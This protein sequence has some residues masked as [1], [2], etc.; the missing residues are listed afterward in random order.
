MNR[1]ST[2]VHTNGRVT[3]MDNPYGDPVSGSNSSSGPSTQSSRLMLYFGS[4]SGVS[5]PAQPSFEHRR[6]RSPLRSTGTSTDPRPI[7]YVSR[8]RLEFVGP[9][10]AELANMDREKREKV[11]NSSAIADDDDDDEYIIPRPVPKQRLRRKP[12]HIQLAPV[13]PR[14]VHTG[15]RPSADGPIRRVPTPFDSKFR[16]GLFDEPLSPI[17]D[18]E[19]SDETDEG[20]VQDE[21]KA[22]PKTQLEIPEV[23]N[24]QMHGSAL[25][26]E[27][28]KK[29]RKRGRWF[30]SAKDKLW[31][32]KRAYNSFHEH[33]L[34][35]FV[36]HSWQKVKSLVSSK[37]DP[38]R[39]AGQ[40]SPRSTLEMPRL[41]RCNA[42]SDDRRAGRLWMASPRFA[43]EE[44]RGT[45]DSNDE[46]M[47]RRC[48]YEAS[49][50]SR[51]TSEENCSPATPPSP[52][53][54]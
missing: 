44:Q 30:W 12:S 50:S 17:D 39:E 28:T 29:N 18:D 21:Q 32:W 46:Q 16:E 35:K 2:F 13:L 38:P 11:L 52:P 22:K 1:Q 53:C 40:S 10:A 6:P 20:D 37:E 26:E 33:R 42:F 8:L 23:E 54:P 3:S 41:R 27:Q 34:G 48:L 51:E 43:T 45:T 19:R 5:A 47:S 49:L 7:R 4:R 36:V 25:V 9:I 31:P 24:E 15:R 14:P